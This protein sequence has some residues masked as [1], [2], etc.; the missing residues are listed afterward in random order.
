MDKK[1]IGTGKMKYNTNISPR[2]LKPG[3]VI[4]LNENIFIVNQI[5]RIGNNSY[6]S[7]MINETGNLIKEFLLNDET[8]ELIHESYK[9][10]KKMDKQ[11]KYDRDRITSILGTECGFQQHN[12]KFKK[13]LAELI[14]NV[15]D[16]YTKDQEE[17]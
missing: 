15:K 9:D 6:C 3:M 12:D 14:M 8:V 13:K 5:N 7:S 11:E 17:L 16:L 1:R 2:Q 10:T 4:K